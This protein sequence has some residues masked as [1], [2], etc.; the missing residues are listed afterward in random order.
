CRDL[1]LCH[2]CNCCLPWPYF[3][4]TVRRSSPVDAHR[5]WGIYDPRRFGPQV[6]GATEEIVRRRGDEGCGARTRVWRRGW[7]TPTREATATLRGVS[8][9]P[10]G[11]TG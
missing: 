2:G 6:A 3:D 10:G 7:R 5:H 11:N 8:V 1:C 9:Q 4:R